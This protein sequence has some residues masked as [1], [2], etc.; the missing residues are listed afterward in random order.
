MAVIDG[1]SGTYTAEVDSHKSLQVQL[2]GVDGNPL[3][4]FKEPAVIS[5]GILNPATIAVSSTYPQSVGTRVAIDGYNT[6]TFVVK[7]SGTGTTPILFRLF[8]SYDGQT[9]FTKYLKEVFIQSPKAGNMEEAFIQIKTQIPF[10]KCSVTTDAVA[11]PTAVIVDS[12][13]G[14]SFSGGGN[15]ESINVY[16]AVIDNAHE[17]RGSY[18]VTFSGVGVATASYSYFAIFNPSGSISN[19]RIDE[20]KLE[21]M[22]LS[23]TAIATKRTIEM[24]SIT[25][26]SG[27]S[28]VI[29]VPLDSKYPTP[30]FSCVNNTIAMTV[31]GTSAPLTSFIC[32]NSNSGGVSVRD[33]VFPKEKAI[34]INPGSGLVFGTSTVA[35]GATDSFI[36]TLGLSEVA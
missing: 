23:T 18:A 33:L 4:A 15:F 24:A 6:C 13:V 20:I 28:V 30:I 2:F 1:A 17:V 11:V 27:G 16:G 25:S 22:F 8:G 31:G 21:T 12:I 14:N 29:P 3:T 19:I 36:I 10:L 5:Y 9:W 7:S 32:N 35:L 34:I 26:L